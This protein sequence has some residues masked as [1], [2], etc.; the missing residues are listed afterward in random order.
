MAEI[1]VLE[2]DKEAQGLVFV[3]REGL[4]RSRYD[5]RGTAEED[6]VGHLFY[7]T[8]HR[9]RSCRCAFPRGRTTSECE[10]IGPYP[11]VLNI[12]LSLRSFVFGD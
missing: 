5:A 12:S 3:D 6:Y 7:G 8:R 4:H 9:H 10:R 1:A 2:R 11:T